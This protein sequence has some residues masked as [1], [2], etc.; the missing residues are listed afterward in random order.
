MQD[1]YAES[2]AVLPIR[3]RNEN[4]KNK[5]GYI[6]EDYRRAIR[7]VAMGF[8]IAIIVRKKHALDPEN[9]TER[10]KY[11]RRFTSQRQGACFVRAINLSR[12]F[13]NKENEMLKGI[14]KIIS[15]ELLKILCEMGHGGRDCNR[16]R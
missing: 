4:V 5:N 14:L 11:T 12:N 3:R 8:R 16:I 6:L 10:Q 2:Y 15:P 13:S 1:V 7:E 9:E